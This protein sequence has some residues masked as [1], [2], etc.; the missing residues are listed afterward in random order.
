MDPKYGSITYWLKFA[1]LY[2]RIAQQIRAQQI[3]LKYTPITT[4]ENGKR[5]TKEINRSVRLHAQI[6]ICYVLRAHALIAAGSRNFA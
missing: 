4:Y 3:T 1:S 5:V 2:I 6:A